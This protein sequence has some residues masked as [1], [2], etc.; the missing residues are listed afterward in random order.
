MKK[1][2]SGSI[3]NITS[4]AAEFGFANNPSYVSSKGALKQMS[5]AMAV[6]LGDH[7]IRVNCICPGYIRT[8][9][10]EKSF[11]NETLHEERLRNMIIPRWGSPNDLV[12]A[13]IFLSS[14]A[15]SYV[16][17]SDLVVDGGWCAKGM[18]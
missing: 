4:I 16:T 10:T 14:D 11:N 18:S 13:A 9:M 5:K 15:S 8:D 17:G 3:I 12:G 1:Q 7:G 2:K 6:D